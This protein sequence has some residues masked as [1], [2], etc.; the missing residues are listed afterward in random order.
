MLFLSTV[1]QTVFDVV[2]QTRI[3]RVKDMLHARNSSMA[4]IADKCGYP[5]VVVL[6]EDEVAKGV[7]TLKGMVERS[8]VDVAI[9]EIADYIPKHK[10]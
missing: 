2:R 5:Y 8:A 4:F 1:G 10:N 7:V 9:E 6:G 3:E